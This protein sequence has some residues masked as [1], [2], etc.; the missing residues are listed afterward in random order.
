ME[1]IKEGS[2]V[3]VLNSLNVCRSI[4][5]VT[6]IFFERKNGVKKVN[7]YSHID[8]THW[9]E[10]FCNVYAISEEEFQKII[11]DKNAIRQNLIASLNDEIEKF[12]DFLAS[13]ANDIKLFGI[14][15]NEEI[16]SCL[17]EQLEDLDW[18]QSSC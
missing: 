17:V 4:A 11:S 18:I 1:E 9:E 15:Y 13:R 6:K 7:L 10:C 8:E 14:K 5:E 2:K 3:R 16:S 12:A